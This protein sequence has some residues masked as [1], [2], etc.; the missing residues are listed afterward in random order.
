MTK[1]LIGDGAAKRIAETVQLV[2]ATEGPDPL[3]SG[4]FQPDALAPSQFC[5]LHRR[6]KPDGRTRLMYAIL[7]DAIRCYVKNANATRNAD[8]KLFSETADWFLSDG[9]TQSPFSFGQICEELGI[10]TERVR[11]RLKTLTASDLRRKHRGLCGRRLAMKSDRDST[12]LSP[13][14]RLLRRGSRADR[15]S[16]ALLLQLNPEFPDGG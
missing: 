16:R 4:V 13:A 11:A 15:Y 10:K 3:T 12:R 14:V 6:T 7:D 2:E 1:L 5:D 9:A 8:R